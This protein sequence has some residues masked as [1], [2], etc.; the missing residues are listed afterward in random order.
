[1]G[2]MA[3]ETGPQLVWIEMHTDQ[4]KTVPFVCSI[5]HALE[6]AELLKEEAERPIA[7]GRA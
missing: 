4:G 3:T 1:V 2:R 5:E 7:A 6:L